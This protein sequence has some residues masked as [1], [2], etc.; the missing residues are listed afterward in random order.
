MIVPQTT[1]HR[2]KRWELFQ[3]MYEALACIEENVDEMPD[4]FKDKAKEL[5]TAFDIF[6]I[7]IVN[8]RTYSVKH[9]LEVEELRNYAIRKIYE[10]IRTYSDYTFSNEKEI[11]ANSLHAVLKR[12][13]TG[14]KISR[15]SQS[16]KSALLTNLLQDLAKPDMEQHLATLHLTKAVAELTVHNQTFEIEQRNR[17]SANAEYV[18]GVVKEA[19]TDVQNAFLKFV[20]VL[21]ALIL[22]EGEEKYAE[23]KQFMTSLLKKHLAQVRQR[24]RKKEEEEV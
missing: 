14:R 11:A 15:M 5:R 18:T 1:F 16:E 24:T 23:L 3:F 2:F 17:L 4:I 21:N 6:D 19:R 8:D 10:V 7:E 20:D 9:L 12:Y 13:G 22:L